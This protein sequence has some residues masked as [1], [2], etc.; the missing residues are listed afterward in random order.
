MAVVPFGGLHRTS[1]RWLEK[2]LVITHDSFRTVP[3]R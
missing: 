1:R 3:A 2:L